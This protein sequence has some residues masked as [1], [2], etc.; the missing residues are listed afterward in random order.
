MPIELDQ[1]S[2][3]N[4]GKAQIGHVVFCLPLA[5]C[6]FCGTHCGM[7]KSS[8]ARATSNQIKTSHNKTKPNRK[9]KTKHNNKVWQPTSRFDLCAE[10]VADKLPRYYSTIYH[11]MHTLC[12]RHEHKHEH[13]YGCGCGC[14]YGHLHGQ[15]HHR[16][17]R[18]AAACRSL[19][20][21]SI[22]RHRDGPSSS[23]STRTRTST[24][25]NASAIIRH[26]KRGC[27][28]RWMRVQTES[29]FNFKQTK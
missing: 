29:L 20:L 6:R 7:P 13:E 21:M 27:S 10:C 16:H 18:D 3:V 24:N 12:P 25:T 23:S 15:G 11:H 26:R 14:G 19:W 17:G 1:I 8:S 22:T 2:C 9:V 4:S 5:T 28:L